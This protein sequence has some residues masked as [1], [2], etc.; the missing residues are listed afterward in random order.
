MLFTPSL[1]ALQR[2][3]RLFVTAEGGKAHVALAR[4]TETDAWRADDIGTIE[5][6]LEELPGAHTV[7]TAHPHVGGIL[8][9]VSLVA[10]TFQNSEHLLG[11]QHVIVDGGL[12]LSLA[13]G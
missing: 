10:E 13:L 2:F 11:V 3:F 6:C 4:G 7:R 5:Q 9:T 1:D 12:H 8:A